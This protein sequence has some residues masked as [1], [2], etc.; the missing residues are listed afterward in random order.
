MNAKKNINSK[1]ILFFF[2]VLLLV[3]AAAFYSSKNENDK[4]NANNEAAVSTPDTSTDKMPVS[5]KRPSINNDNTSSGHDSPAPDYNNSAAAQG[6]IEASL[7]TEAPVERP[8]HETREVDA[9]GKKGTITGNGV[10]IRK[11]SRIDSNNANVIIKMNKG[12]KVTII[13]AEKPINGNK[14]WYKIKLND[15]RTGFVREDLIKIE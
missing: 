4:I 7:N 12:D 13:G 11:E 1:K 5:E 10:N 9:R 6:S 15:G 8:E 2:I 14:I 3:A